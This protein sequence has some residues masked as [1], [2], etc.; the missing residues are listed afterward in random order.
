MLCAAAALTALTAAA[1]AQSAP[2]RSL[3]SPRLDGVGEGG[4]PIRDSLIAP[5]DT[6]ALAPNGY[7]GGQYRTAAGELV[8]I[9]ASNSYPM[10]PAIGSAGPTS[11]PRSCT[12]RSSPPSP[13]SCRRRTRSR[14]SADDRRSRATAR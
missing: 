10:D 3:K 8:T 2:A 4:G 9:Y 12:G 1:V 14:T 5:R 7:W 11:L 13:C 6:L